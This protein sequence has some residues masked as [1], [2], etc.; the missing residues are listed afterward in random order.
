MFNLF[1][2]HLE[3]NRGDVLASVS[4][5]RRAGFSPPSAFSLTKLPQ[6]KPWSSFKTPGPH[7]L[8]RPLI[9]NASAW[10]MTN[11]YIYKLCFVAIG[12]SWSVLKSLII[13]TSG[14]KRRKKLF[15]PLI[16]LKETLVYINYGIKSE[17][18]PELCVM[19][20]FELIFWRGAPALRRCQWEIMWQTISAISQLQHSRPEQPS[21]E[22]V[23][24]VHAPE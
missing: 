2:S 20:C 8:N 5:E 13:F 11:M 16:P 18:H 1:K 22:P 15:S 7:V 9:A 4:S 24:G 23:W 6:I 17:T 19:K 3:W 12:E 21:T 14:E 10:V